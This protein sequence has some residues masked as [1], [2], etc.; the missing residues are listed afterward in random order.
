MDLRPYFGKNVIV[1]DVIILF[2]KALLQLEQ[3]QETLMII[4]MK[5]I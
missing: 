4:A 1:T 5:L 3:F 2:I